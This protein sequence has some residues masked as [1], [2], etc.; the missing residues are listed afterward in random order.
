M[1]HAAIIRLWP[2]KEALASDIG[3]ARHRV[4]MWHFRNSIPG[5][6]FAAIVDAAARRE[7]KGVTLQG[8]CDAAAKRRRRIK[9]RIPS[10]RQGAAQAA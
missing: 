8:L 1:D 4:N 5:Y 2:S 10:D 7:F 6:A 3:E 9:R